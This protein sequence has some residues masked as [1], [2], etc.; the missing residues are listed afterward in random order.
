MLS[1]PLKIL[2]SQAWDGV[3]KYLDADDICRLR[4]TGEKSVVASCLAS[5]RSLRLLSG[6]TDVANHWLL[7]S[8][9]SLNLK[10]LDFASAGDVQRLASMLPSSRLTSIKLDFFD[11]R[12]VLSLPPTLTSLDLGH[13]TMME[14]T[15]FLV[16]GDAKLVHFGYET[17]CTQTRGATRR[18]IHY[19][20]ETA[21]LPFSATLESLDIIPYRD[22]PSLASS[23][24]DLHSFTNLTTL[25]ADCDWFTGKNILFPPTITNLTCRGV[26]TDTT[27]NDIV[28]AL[29]RNLHSLHIHDHHDHDTDS[30]NVSDLDRLERLTIPRSITA[31]ECAP[32]CPLTLVSSDLEN[33]VIHGKERVSIHIPQLTLHYGRLPAESIMSRLQWNSVTNIIFEY[34]NSDI[35]FAT[36]DYGCL[37]LAVNVRYVRIQNDSVDSF[38]E[39]GGFNFFGNFPDLQMLS[40]TMSPDLLRHICSQDE[41]LPIYCKGLHLSL[42]PPNGAPNLLSQSIPCTNLSWLSRMP[43]RLEFCDMPFC[44]HLI[45]L[46]NTTTSKLSIQCVYARP[47]DACQPV[48]FTPSSN[49]KSFCVKFD[50]MASSYK[51]LDP[52]QEIFAKYFDYLQWAIKYKR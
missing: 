10:S 21:I 37:K 6:R 30:L 17:I 35:V 16:L 27:I 24:F 49:L 41:K 40:W 47:C 33:L 29:G 23:P 15:Q 11:A 12:V 18:C 7:S 44:G 46:C 5:V 26:F 52:I 43:K 38:I 22:M 32:K 8:T 13:V 4:E 45:S 51:L 19:I 3:T 39:R 48:A 34:P 20:F 1:S 9:I 42:C 36:P 25:T 50:V 31:L 28:A 2:D 14:T